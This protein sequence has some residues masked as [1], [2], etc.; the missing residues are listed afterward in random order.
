MRARDS[1][2]IMRPPL[3]VRRVITD[4][5]DGTVVTFRYRG[6]MDFARIVENRTAYLLLPRAYRPEP[7]TEV[8]RCVWKDA[9]LVERGRRVAT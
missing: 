1:E 5:P 6:E 9:T 3:P 2:P 7:G 4:L 8:V